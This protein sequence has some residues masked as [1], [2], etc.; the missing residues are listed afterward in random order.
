MDFLIQDFKRVESANKKEN[1]ELIDLLVKSSIRN[2]NKS[3]RAKVLK[4]SDE[5]VWGYK[6]FNRQDVKKR[7][8]L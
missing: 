8:E 6:V 4:Y 3:Q 2:S 5:C 1:V 7:K